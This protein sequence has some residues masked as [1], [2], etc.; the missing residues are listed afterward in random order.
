MFV[1]HRIVGLILM[2][3]GI[4]AEYFLI[5]TILSGNLVK[6]Q[7]SNQIFAATV[8]PVSIPISIGLV[9]FGYF[10]LRGEYLKN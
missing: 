2:L 1:I 3:T 10:A 4:V 5:L 9:I 6:D 8:I 7:A